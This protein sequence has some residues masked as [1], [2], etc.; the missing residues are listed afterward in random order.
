LPVVY[1]GV[2]LDCGYRLDF[3]V[4]ESLLVELKAVNELTSV[5][6]AQVLTYLKLARL[7]LGL[8]LN[9]NVAV[10]KDGMKRLAVGDVFR[11]DWRLGE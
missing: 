8:L 10:L 5:H 3:V 6:H 2:R 11:S 1:K 9:F 7:P 4:E